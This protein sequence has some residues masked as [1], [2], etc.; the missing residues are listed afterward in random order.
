MLFLVVLHYK[1]RG[2]PPKPEPGPKIN[3]QP[4]QW[5]GH[6]QEF[7][8]RNNKKTFRPGP[9]PARPEKML[10]SNRGGR[11]LSSRPCGGVSN[12]RLKW[13]LAGTYR[14]FLWR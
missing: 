6:G 3:A 1:M 2:G 4:V 5:D 12:R 9:N 10:T 11:C 7:S 14:G 8:S 13:Q